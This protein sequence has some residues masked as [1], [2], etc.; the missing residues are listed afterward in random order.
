MPE[1]ILLIGAFDVKGEEYAHVRRLIRGQGCDVLTLDIS[2]LGRT[3]R[4]PVDIDSAAVARAGGGDIEELRRAKDR[5]A[6]LNVMARGAAELARRLHA[7]GRFQGVLALGG[8][9]G[10]GVATAAMRALPIGVPKVM[11]TTMAGAD[12]AAFV[13]FK[14]VTLIPSIVDVA[15]INRISARIF[16]EAVGAVCGMV[17][18]HE[19]ALPDT[20]PLIAATMFGNTTPCVDRCREALSGRGYEVLV[21]HCTGTGGRTMESLVEEGHIAAV[22]DVTTTEWADELCGGVLSAG[23]SRLEAPGRAGI[24]HLIAP[25][26]LDMVNFGAPD[27][28]PP[29]YRERMLYQWN[30]TV[31]LMRTNVEESA[32]LGEILAHKANAAT[33]PVAFLLPLQG[34]SMLDKPGERF[35]WPEADRAL[36]DAIRRHLRPGIEVAEM[37]CNIN[38][39]AFADRAVEMLL[40][41]M[42]AHAEPPSRNAR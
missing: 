42:G 25:G 40:R 14:D 27:T 16:A 4:F 10:T 15:G 6:A 39:P 3:D 21:F 32:R 33:G 26:C 28:V 8:G 13:G 18:M 12:T 11:V 38:D 5:G 31:T 30:P 19:A 41:L 7:D 1:T 22:L 2:V 36:Y 24:P 34:V 37:D 35:W 23:P 20:R 17:G 29:R 9:G